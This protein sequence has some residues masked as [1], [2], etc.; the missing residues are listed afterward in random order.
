M[1]VTLNGTEYT[2]TAGQYIAVSGFTIH[3]CR[4]EPDSVRWVM[5]IPG[6]ALGGGIRR[7]AGKASSTF[8]S[9]RKSPKTRQRRNF[10][11]PPLESSLKRPPYGGLG[12]P[13]GCTPR[14]ARRRKL[15]IIR[16]RFSA[17]THS[18]RCSAF[19]HRTRFAG[20]RWGPGL[21]PHQALFARSQPFCKEC[22]ERSAEPAQSQYRFCAPEKG[23]CTFRSG[24]VKRGVQRGE[25]LRE[26]TAC[27]PP[28]S[29]ERNPFGISLVTFCMSRK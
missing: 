16:F 3:G 13:F 22:N 12:P 8:C 2:L 14:G 15:R 5:L 28:P 18:L 19:P 1:H 25:R 9:R 29:P 10:D 20:L 23:V 11:F 24:P 21:C 6:G 17:K 27:R 4:L 7:D 26:R